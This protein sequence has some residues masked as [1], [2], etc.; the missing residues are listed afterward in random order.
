MRYTTG[1]ASISFADNDRHPELNKIEF[2]ANTQPPPS[3]DDDDDGRTK[4]DI[5]SPQPQQQQQQLSFFRAFISV[6]TPP[7][8]RWIFL[9]RLC[10]FPI[11]DEAG[12]SRSRPGISSGHKFSTPPPL[13]EA[14]GSAPTTADSAPTDWLCS[15][16][17]SWRVGEPIWDDKYY[18]ISQ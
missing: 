17:A 8:P 9:G 3:I 11:Q 10:G 15:E 1:T 4:T 12:S 5:T 7:T 6:P 18:A 14:S 16:R 2:S 13:C